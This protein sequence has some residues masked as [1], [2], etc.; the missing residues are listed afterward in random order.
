MPSRS[1]RV[2]PGDKREIEYRA[3]HLEMRAAGAPLPSGGGFAGDHAT[4]RV[5]RRRDSV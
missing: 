2:K 1:D 4:W 3:S 5:V